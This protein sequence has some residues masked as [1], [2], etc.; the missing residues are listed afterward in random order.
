MNSQWA[1]IDQFIEQANSILVTSHIDPDGDALGSTLAMAYVCKQWGKRVIC[2]NES[3][4]PR[5]FSFLPKIDEVRRPEQVNESFEYVIVVDA[6]DRKRV[7][8]TVQQCFHP[9]AQILNI[10]HHRTNDEFGTINVVMPNVCATAGILYQWMKNSAKVRWDATLATYLYTG[11]LT[12][13]GGFRYSNTSADVL[14]MAAQLVDYGAQADEI[15][16][17]AL[18]SSSYEQIRCLERALSTLS[19]SEDGQIAWLS[20]SLA[21]VK[22]IQANDADV[23]GIVDIPR[24]IEGVDVGI[25]F[26]ETSESTVKVSFRSKK[27]VDVSKIAQEFGGGGH[28]RAAG[29]TVEGGLEAVK[30]Q[31]LKRVKAELEWL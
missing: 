16:D 21:D 9:Q 18:E 25:F 5:R 10:D 8:E 24:K 31:V 23:E 4:I 11:I 12:D 30:K 27:K 3:P 2:V 20:L 15:A 14:R 7:G 17:Y 6:A 26:R 1:T 29:C 28:P 19:L 13:T 22:W